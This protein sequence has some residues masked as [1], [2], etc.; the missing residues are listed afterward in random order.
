MYK[1]L[2]I[3]MGEKKVGFSKIS[4]NTYNPTDPESLFR[5]LTRKNRTS[6]IQSLW[7]H[8]ADILRDYM[9]NNKAR[10]IALELP[11]GSG[12]TLVGLLIGEYR[13]I[14]NGERILYLCP[15]RQLVNQVLD[16]AAEYNIKAHAF[17]GR[18]NDYSTEDFSDFLNADAIA[19][20][21]YSALFNQGRRF[22][23]SNVIICD[24]AHG[25]ESYIASMW[26]LNI[27][28]FNDLFREIIDLFKDVLP[29]GFVDSLS[30]PTS[31]RKNT[32]EKVHSHH[33]YE[34]I[35]QLEELLSSRISKEEPSL[36]YSYLSIQDN[37]AACNMYI[38]SSGILI[39]PWIPPTQSH[40]PFISANQ[41]I[42]M[43]ATLGKG[44]ELER[45]TGIPEIK[46]LSIPAGWDKQ[47]SGR[48]FFV[49]P[50]YKHTMSEYI[51]FIT[52]NINKRDR[53]LIL[54]P[55]NQTAEIIKFKLDECGVNHTYYYSGDIEESLDN[56]IADDKAVLI[57]TNRYDGIDLAED[58]CRQLI[59]AG[60]PAAANLQERFLLS[61]LGIISILKDRIR[62]RFT[63]AAGRCTRG[64]SDYSVVIP[65][66]TDLFKY[67]QT[68]ENREEMHPELHA[69]LKFGLQQSGDNELNDLSELID[70]FMEHG[71]E[72][73]GAEEEIEYFR[74]NLVF[75]EDSRSDVL[76]SVVK[77][78]VN[79]QYCL[80]N[81]RYD[82]ALTQARKIVDSLSGDEF[83]DY[84]ALWSYFAGSAALLHAQKSNDSNY[85]EICDQ[86]FGIATKSSQTISWFSSL[87]SPKKST[88]S[89]DLDLLSGYAIE[90]I[91]AH[92]KKLGLVGPK[93]EDKIND[94][95]DLISDNSSSNFEL[96]IT[97]LGQL[98]GFETNHPGSTA[99]PDSVWTLN[100]NILVLFEAKSEEK[101]D[102]SVFVQTCRQAHGH[103]NW[104]KENISN[105]DDF[106]E[107]ICVVISKKSKL[108]AEA[109]AHSN[110][111][112]YIH[113]DEMREMFETISGIFRRIRF[114]SIEVNDDQM[115]LKI[116]DELKS[117]KLEPKSLIETFKSRP[118]KDLN[119]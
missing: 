10:D 104:A 21:T 67:C 1:L 31:S 26:S 34:R 24:D 111:L 113:I 12:K 92:I 42:Y 35:D 60:L 117:A 8:Q 107:K 4:S 61:R 109:V 108:A 84:R 77:N 82:D 43:S 99:T 57:L 79:F 70:M 65:I 83:T 46:K 29:K 95:R 112:Y 93:F 98:L 33:F 116:Y 20:S 64:A 115:R 49:L 81:K 39:R 103:H 11:T 118:L 94:I 90:N 85:L 73:D 53:T 96:G 41:R 55:D 110:D 119:K 9:S 32:I 28:S 19:I 3:Y 58:A 68:K 87:H 101:D 75:K 74:D 45:I 13:R 66:G 72:W 76:S 80:W 44:G 40:D 71:D 30:N 114:Q 91:Q 59:I 37:L 47:G 89:I 78:E 27:S 22:G 88:E 23:D 15:T 52:E 6:T 48:R 14:V 50:D 56:F 106:D 86:F 69:E 2:F 7:S 5:D 100:D 25:A 102:G 38:S 16:K 62:T 63:Q 51:H 105:Y 36:F 18:Q 54:C 97:K 17:V